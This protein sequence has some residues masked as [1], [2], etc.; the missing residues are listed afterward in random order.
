MFRISAST[1]ITFCLSLSA[2]MPC[3]AGENPDPAIQYESFWQAQPKS[4]PRTTAVFDFDDDK[5]GETAVTLV[6]SG[7]AKPF[8]VGRWGRG[9][10]MQRHGAAVISGLALAKNLRAEGAVTLDFF[11]RPDS[12]AGAERAVLL[13]L[14]G[15]S[16][17]DVLRL[18]RSKDG[19]STLWFKDT[20]LLTHARR[21]AP[22]AWTHIA[23]VLRYS[24]KTQRLVASLSLDGFTQISREEASPTLEPAALD[25]LLGGAASLG[26]FTT[27]GTGRGFAGVI[28]AVR[29]SRGVRGFYERTDAPFLDPEA[30]REIAR[31]MPCISMIQPLRAYFGFD[32]TAAPSPLSDTLVAVGQPQPTDFVPGVRGK[33]M[34][35]AKAAE[36]KIGASGPNLMALPAGTIEFWLRPLDWDNFSVGGYF[37]EGVKFVPILHVGDATGEGP[38]KSMALAIN[39]GRASRLIDE[40]LVPIHPGVWTHVVCAWN[41]EGT[42]VYLNGVPQAIE[43]ITFPIAASLLQMKPGSL[44]VRDRASAGSDAW[45]LHLDSSNTFID[46]L[47][48][49]AHKLSAIEAGNAFSR[50]FPDA[51]TRM[52]PMQP[53]NVS[54]R[55]A[56][57]SWLRLDISCTPFYGFTPNAVKLDFGGKPA[58]TGMAIALDALGNA[59][60]FLPKSLDFGTYPIR[61]ESYAL[62]DGVSGAIPRNTRPVAVLDTKYVRERPAWWHN[63]IGKDRIVPAPWTPIA[64]KGT[65]FEASGKAVSLDRTGLPAQVRCLDADLL[66]RPTQLYGKV[67]GFDVLFKGQGVKM[68][69]VAQ[70]VARWTSS[71]VGG[72]VRADME[73]SV[74]F[75]GLMKFVVTL[76]STGSEPAT[77]DKLTLDFPMKKAHATQIIVSGGNG[78]LPGARAWAN[79]EDAAR[80]RLI[81]G[82][83]SGALPGA[84]VRALDSGE[85]RVWD[86]KSSPVKK[87]VVVGNFCPLVWI[88]DND[89]GLCFFGESDRGWT[90]SADVAAQEVWR[91]AD[92]VTYR[93]CVIS[94]PVTLREARQFTFYVQPTPTKPLPAKDGNGLNPGVIDE[95]IGVP[96][97]QRATASPAT[98]TFRLEPTSWD[99][100]AKLSERGRKIAGAG[101]GGSLFKYV[102]ARWPRFGPSMDDY[103]DGLFASHS[104][105]WTREAEDYFVWSLSEYLKRGLIDG[106]YFDDVSFPP[107]FDPQCG[108]YKLPEGITQPAFGT[109]GLRRVFKRLWIYCDQNGKRPITRARVGA[110][111]EVP[112]MSFCESVVGPESVI[113]AAR[114]FGVATVKEAGTK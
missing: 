42:A 60:V 11:I 8:P 12:S 105:S 75:D 48:V 113:D 109:M 66:A 90:P 61:L 36:Q 26:N 103:S 46:E 55:R 92:T 20:P 16:M 9:L 106:V 30:T 34:S 22:D 29:I 98:Y 33:A 97:T 44:P 86:S 59:Q 58:D 39:T 19:K 63:T 100:A 10:A 7:D 37:G 89:R 5:P 87:G 43:Q 80:A 85:G 53:I 88:G 41:A 6:P 77:I 27:P 23:L 70:D 31:G 96:L 71:L 15:A 1:I 3:A 40:P 78:P 57:N 68:D 2:V 51:V 32:N 91:D 74:E 84:E 82:K 81:A 110:N 101:G 24:D 83:D 64:V 56:A 114:R 111:L 62:S 28:D 69:D 108:A 4:D 54:F 49:Y 79:H 67:N 13:S 94:K 47:H 45:N 93:M 76:K 112:V 73:S 107:T 95:F 35:L 65:T 52:K 14:S 72:G 38:N 18:E 102:D 50:Y 21:I 17:A 25:A 99:D 104:L